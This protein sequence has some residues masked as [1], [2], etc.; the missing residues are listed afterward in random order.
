MKTLPYGFRVVGHKTARRRPIRHAA[1]FAA[2][3]ECDPRAEIDRE[4]YLSHFTFDRALRRIPGAGRDGSR[5]QR[6]LRGPLA[7]VGR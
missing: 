5:L 2:Y 4:A 7:L 3:A 1:A 6:P